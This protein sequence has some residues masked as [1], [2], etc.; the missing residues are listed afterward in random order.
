MSKPKKSKELVADPLTE[1]MFQQKNRKLRRSYNEK[2]RMCKE[3]EFDNS[4][5]KHVIDMEINSYQVNASSQM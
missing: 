5:L 1:Q 3:S 4:K 2:K